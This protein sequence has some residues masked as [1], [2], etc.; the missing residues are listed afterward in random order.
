MVEAEPEKNI[1]DQILFFLTQDQIVTDSRNKSPDRLVLEYITAN[2]DQLMA[3]YP[4]LLMRD[5]LKNYL[6]QNPGETLATPEASSRI[7]GKINEYLSFAYVSS[8]LPHDFVLLS[9]ERTL[10]LF[11]LLYPIKGIVYES[12]IEE[13]LGFNSISGV[14]VPD[15][16][17]VDIT[18]IQPVIVGYCEYTA[19]TADDRVVAKIK[20]H[21]KNL[22][23]KKG[24]IRGADEVKDS[25]VVMEHLFSSAAAIVVTGH[26][27]D[28]TIEP[29]VSSDDVDRFSH[30][31][32]RDLVDVHCAS[33]KAIHLTL[34]F[35]GKTL[36]TFCNRFIADVTNEA[37]G[38][39]N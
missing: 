9:P 15:G 11:S 23:F 13:V 4:L 2:Y 19:A 34:P 35:Y 1:I 33:N 28:S 5:S 7:V 18:S 12:A 31:A 16:L 32:F 27:K 14:S 25:D 17:V 38:P 6:S 29:T 20:D 37:T 22:Q 24:L 39:I 10:A 8:L 26:T 3:W 21:E 36:S 30:S